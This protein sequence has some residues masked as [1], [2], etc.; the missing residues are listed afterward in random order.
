VFAYGITGFP[1]TFVIDPTGTV[2]GNYVAS[3]LEPVLQHQLQALK[4]K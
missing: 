2:V 4:G 3:E 1:T